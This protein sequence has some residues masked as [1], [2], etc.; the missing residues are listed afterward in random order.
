MQRNRE[1]KMLQNLITAPIASRP[2]IVSKAVGDH[3]EHLKLGPNGE[4]L[5]VADPAT[6]TPFYSMKEAMRIALRLPSGLRAFGMPVEIEAAGLEGP[7][8]H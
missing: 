6:A 2:A 8:L 5:W 3:A 1:A 7:A 4:A